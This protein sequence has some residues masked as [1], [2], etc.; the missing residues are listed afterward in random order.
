MVVKRYTSQEHLNILKKLLSTAISAAKN[1]LVSGRIPCI[2]SKNR[3]S[4]TIEQS[5]SFYSEFIQ[6]RMYFHP[7]NLKKK[8]ITHDLTFYCTHNQFVWAT[9]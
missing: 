5:S 8:E 3:R 7:K 9:V 4:E 6:F 2:S 1:G